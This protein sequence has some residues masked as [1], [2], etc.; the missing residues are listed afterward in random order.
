MKSLTL[1]NF[2]EKALRA[3][4]HRVLKFYSDTCPLCVSLKKVMERLEKEYD[5]V[6][7]YS[8]NIDKEKDLSEL[9]VKDGVPTLYYVYEN[10]I[11]E[12]PYPYENPDRFSGY[13]E[14]E[15]KKYLTSKVKN[16]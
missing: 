1:E 11:E 8:I 16:G 14:K 15:L 4:D 10:I 13:Q 5:N 12:I 6:S 7:F 2:E 3:K 9:F